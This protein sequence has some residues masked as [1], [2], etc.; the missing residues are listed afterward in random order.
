MILQ[1][2]AR[3]AERAANEGQVCPA[4]AAPRGSAE[5][6]LAAAP[7]PS[8]ANRGTR[9]PSGCRRALMPRRPAQRPAAKGGAGPPPEAVEVALA[10]RRLA[11]AAV[12]F[13]A[14]PST[15]GVCPAP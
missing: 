1:Q 12:L 14:T 3:S 6:T 13:R 5:R 4:P 11:E 15:E 10:R 7:G 2:E 8:S 9:H